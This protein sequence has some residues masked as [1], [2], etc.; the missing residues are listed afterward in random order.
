LFLHRSRGA[1]TADVSGN[2]A[3]R[4]AR[5]GQNSKGIPSFSSDLQPGAPANIFHVIQLTAVASIDTRFCFRS[6]MLTTKYIEYWEGE[7]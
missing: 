5:E 4:S 6:S 1:L 7:G 3:D 2:V